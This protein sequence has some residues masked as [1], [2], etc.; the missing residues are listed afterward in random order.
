M[1]TEG[2]GRRGGDRKMRRKRRR[3]NKRNI[4]VFMSLEG[5]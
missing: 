1:K 4:K 2:R 5:L 3:M